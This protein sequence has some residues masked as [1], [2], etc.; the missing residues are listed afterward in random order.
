MGRSHRRATRSRIPAGEEQRAAYILTTWRGRLTR[1]IWL[2]RLHTVPIALRISSCV[3]GTGDGWRPVWA[4][5]AQKR[6]LFIGGLLQ[7][8]DPHAYG[9]VTIITD[10]RFDGQTLTV[11]GEK[12]SCSASIFVSAKLSRADNARLRTEGG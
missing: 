8:V 3:A 4:E 10:V 9:I 11:V 1:R 2:T 6:A 7:A 5:I 12:Y